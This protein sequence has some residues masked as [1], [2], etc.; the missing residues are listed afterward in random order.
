MCK[1]CIVWWRG[2]LGGI[3]IWSHV[4]S[5]SDLLGLGQTESLS[6]RNSLANNWRA[7]TTLGTSQ[8]NKVPACNCKKRPAG[9]G[10]LQKAF[11]FMQKINHSWI[12][13]GGAFLLV[14]HCHACDGRAAQEKRWRDVSYWRAVLAWE[15]NEEQWVKI[16]S[17]SQMGRR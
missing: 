6:A 13:F 2:K 15:I 14:K 3:F 9:T 12:R 4:W 16:A 10:F 8:C 7:N 17:Q 1:L 5:I 11:E